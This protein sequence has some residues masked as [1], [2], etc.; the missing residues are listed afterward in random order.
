[1][2][3]KETV[4]TSHVLNLSIREMQANIVAAEMMKHIINLDSLIQKLFVL[5]SLTNS[6][7]D[8]EVGIVL[9]LMI[10]K[11]LSLFL[12]RIVTFGVPATVLMPKLA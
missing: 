9:V 8:L 6:R 4:F 7:V 12:S 3:L 11:S 1:M 5:K 10:L 2:T